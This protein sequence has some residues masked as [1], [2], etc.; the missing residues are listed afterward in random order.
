MRVG[1]P[2]FGQSVLFEVSISFLRS[3][4]FAILAIIYLLAKILPQAAGLDEMNPDKNSGVVSKGWE[5]VLAALD[6]T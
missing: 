4:V 5:S 6:F 2:H 3:A 1:L